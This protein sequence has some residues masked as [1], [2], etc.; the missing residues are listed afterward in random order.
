MVQLFQV[1]ERDGV[2][3]FSQ[4]FLDSFLGHCLAVLLELLYCLNC[5]ITV[6][7]KLAYCYLTMALPAKSNLDMIAGNE[8][9]NILLQ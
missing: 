7:L 6:F 3:N 8:I 4:N 9:N 1:L 2:T 5:C